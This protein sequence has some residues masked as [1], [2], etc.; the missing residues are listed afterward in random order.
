MSFVRT[1]GVVL[2]GRVTAGAVRA[3]AVALLTAVLDGGAA[4]V[5]GSAVA[6]PVPATDEPPRQGGATATL[7]GLTT[8]GQ[9]VVRED[10]HA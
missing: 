10:G 2:R 4:G 1:A 9:A 5:G 8:Y 6:A 3:F 7:E